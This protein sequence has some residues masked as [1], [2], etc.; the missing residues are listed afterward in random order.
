[1][2]CSTLCLPSL[3]AFPLVSPNSSTEAAIFLI[4]LLRQ[5]ACGSIVGWGSMLQAG[6]LCVW[7]LMRSLEFSIYLILP[8]ALWPCR[9]LSLL[10]KWVS[11]IF[12][13]VKGVSALK[14]TT[15]IFLG[16]KG[17]SALR[18]TTSLPSVSRLS[19]TCGSLNVSNPM[20]LWGL[21]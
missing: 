12:L 1:M 7:F 13:G 17:I 6:S 8:A 2:N 14:L 4:L 20:G 5:G 9:Q 3:L 18:L 10:Q 11:G 19:R 16:V 21:L 15:G